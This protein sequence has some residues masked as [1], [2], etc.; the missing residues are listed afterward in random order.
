MNPL[1]SYDYGHICY[2]GASK[3]KGKKAVEKIVNAKRFDMLLNIIRG[4]NPEG[5]AYGVEALMIAYSKDASIL[6]QEDKDAI[7][8]IINS[9]IWI[10]TCA[11]C[12]GQQRSYIEVFWESRKS[13][14]VDR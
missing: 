6:N 2:Y 9:N 12:L 4:Y 10:N 1:E 8:K 14:S 7:K 3:P 5:R 11:G 13:Y